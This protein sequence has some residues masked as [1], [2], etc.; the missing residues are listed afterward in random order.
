MAVQIGCFQNVCGFIILQDES[1]PPNVP[2]K[3]SKLNCPLPTSGVDPSIAKK[4]GPR[5]LSPD[6]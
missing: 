1:E 5:S 3:K 6:H 4:P 2:V